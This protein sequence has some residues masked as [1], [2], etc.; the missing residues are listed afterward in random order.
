MNIINRILSK[1]SLI[2][3]KT[4]NLSFYRSYHKLFLISL[5]SLISIYQ[6][7]AQSLSGKISA[8]GTEKYLGGATVELKGSIHQTI[9]TDQGGNF[10]FDNLL[11]GKYSLYIT[12]IGFESW[13]QDIERNK[14]DIILQISLVPSVYNLSN[15]LIVSASRKETSSAD[16][17]YA[18]EVIND[19]SRSFQMPRSTPEALAIVPGVFVQKTNH[20]GGSPF[21]RGLTGN[22]TLILVDGIRLNNSTFRYGPNQYLNTIDPFTIHKM[23]VLKGSGSVQYGSDA[24][25]GVVQVLTKEPRFAD[26]KGLSGNVTLKYW[27]G[28]M[29]KTG[30]GEL[31]YSAPKM[32][33]LAGISIKDFGDLIGGDKT[34]RQSPSGYTEMD[35]DIKLKLKIT[36]QAE[37]ILANQF[38]QQK[39]V[40]VFHKI[41][42]ENFMINEMERQKRNLSYLKLNLSPF[43]PYFKVVNIRASLNQTLEVRN[44]QKN[45]NNTLRKEKDEVSTANAAVDLFSFFNDNWTANS[46]IEYY[47]DRV[48]STRKDMNTLNQ[49]FEN[50]RGLYPDGATYKNLSIYN[51]HHLK[52]HHF[53]LEAGVRYNWFKA[54]IEDENLGKVNLSPRALVFNAGLNYKFKQHH[55]YS[56]LSS[57]YRAP[58]IDDMGTLGIVDFRYEIPS[59][60]LKPEKNFN[61]E[62]GYK[63]H[64]KKWNVTSAVFFNHLNDLIAR[65][66]TD[67]KINGYSV[68]KKENIEK[69]FIKGAEISINYQPGQRLVLRNFVSYTFGKNL[70]KNEPM[71][72][73]PPLNGYSSLKYTLAKIYFMG[74]LCWATSQT[75]LAQGD[76][77]DNRIPP[78]GTPGWKVFNLYSGYNLKPLQFR[79]SAQNLFNKDYRTHGSGINAVGRS[80][81]LSMQYEF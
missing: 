62:T 46:G 47:Q 45:G 34:R 78:G 36:D 68:Y 26:I 40:V 55:F 13:K 27:N 60:D 6:L 32:A 33:L 44:S 56:S 58:N 48:G 76:K 15:I 41:K 14:R 54:S 19:P 69:A 63:Y 39:N 52:L 37:L 21:I 64:S 38:V 65:V 71:R 31:M 77:E 8:L 67:E 49:S 3:S 61:F 23:E 35:T 18:T 9:I 12:C 43:N 16:L 7:P 73:I 59:Y 25:G 2:I 1:L 53:N 79:L 29:E 50:L 10:N 4:H 24:L 66:K 28:D 57:G 51:L 75:R 74:E 42:L 70:T 20:G 11:P 17:P 80:I 81:W 22:Q 72:R 30:R 5:I